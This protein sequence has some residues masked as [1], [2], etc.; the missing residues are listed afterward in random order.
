MGWGLDQPL[1]PVPE[2][3]EPAQA[4]L[5]AALAPTWV[6]V[7]IAAICAV[8]TEC[9]FRGWLQWRSG[10]LWSIAL[11]TL[12]CSPLDPITGVASGVALTAVASRGGAFAALVAHLCW[13]ATSA[14][15]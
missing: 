14:I 13:I 1:S 4:R 5:F 8:A 15:L 7:G 9:L 6:G 3:W 2:G 10:A 12:V 11:W